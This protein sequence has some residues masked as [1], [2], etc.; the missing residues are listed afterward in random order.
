MKTFVVLVN[1]TPQGVHAIKDSPE[2]A[3]KFVEQLEASGIAVKG[4]Y[5]TLGAYDGLLILASEDEEATLAAVLSLAKTG[6]VQTQTLPAYD[7]AGF[8]ALVSR[9]A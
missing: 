6:N 2:R 8:A 4:Q 3:G 5:W 7:R 9:L 1:F